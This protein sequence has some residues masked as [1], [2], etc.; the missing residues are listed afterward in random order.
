MGH[1]V[2]PSIHLHVLHGCQDYMYMYMD[3]SRQDKN[4]PKTNILNGKLD[5]EPFA[6]CF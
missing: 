1:R 5:T 4:V 3:R 6:Y 2:L